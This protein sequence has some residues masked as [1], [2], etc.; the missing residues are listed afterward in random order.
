MFVPAKMDIYVIYEIIVEMAF[1]Q[2]KNRDTEA[3]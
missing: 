3:F 1:K 2:Q